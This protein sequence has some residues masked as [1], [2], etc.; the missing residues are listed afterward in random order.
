MNALRATGFALL[1]LLLVACDEDDKKQSA[2]A[3]L[4]PPFVKAVKLERMDVPLYATFMGQTQGS[5]S[6]AV[7]PQVSGI[8]QKRLF[9]EGAYVKQGTVLFQIDEAPFQAALRQA[10]GQ[11][12]EAVSTLENARKEYD[13][14]QKLYAFQRRKPSGARTAP[15][16]PSRK[17]AQGRRGFGCS[18][19]RQRGPDTT[20]VLPGKSSFFRFYQP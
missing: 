12:A 20:R 3:S 10:E 13:R 2:G 17:G 4:P 9:R 15:M 1:C 6:A 18:G 19:R 14:V 8:L 11:L 7:K 16:R 5:R